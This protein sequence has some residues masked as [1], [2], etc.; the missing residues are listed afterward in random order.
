MTAE[1]ISLY[2]TLGALATFSRAELGFLSKSDN[3]FLALSEDCFQNFPQLITLFLNSQ[4]AE[5]F[6]QLEEYKVDYLLDP[7]LY[8]VLNELF[9]R[10]KVRAY[11]QYLS[12][13]SNVSLNYMAKAFNMKLAELEEEIK[14]LIESGTVSI[15]IDQKYGVCN[16]LQTF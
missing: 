9:Y 3:V 1:D 11:V 15:L 16:S 2:I 12:V 4:F 5:L 10:I 7:N 8:A 6:N 13:F 14:Q